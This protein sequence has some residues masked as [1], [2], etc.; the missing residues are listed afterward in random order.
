MP[1]RSAA[2]CVRAMSSW[3]WRAPRP[4]PCSSSV[5]A[6]VLFLDREH[7]L[8]GE[9]SSAAP[10]LLGHTCGAGTAFVQA[11]SELVDVK[12][13]RDAVAYLEALWGAD[14][15]RHGGRHAESAGARALRFAPPRHPLR[16]P[17]GRR[18]RAPHHR[19]DRAHF[20]AAPGA[21]HHR[22]TGT[23]RGNLRQTPG[24]R[25]RFASRAQAGL[26]AGNVDHRRGNRHGRTA[27]ARRGPAASR[28]CHGR[29]DRRSATPE[30][31]VARTFDPVESG[32]LR[33]DPGRVRRRQRRRGARRARPAR[34]TGDS[35]PSRPSCRSHGA[36]QHR[37]HRR[38]FALRRC[39]RPDRRVTL[40]ARTPTSTWPPPSLRPRPPRP[41]RVPR[42]GRIRPR[43]S[44]RRMR[45]CPRCSR[46]SCTSRPRA[47]RG[48]SP[49]RATRPASC[50]PSSNYPRA[51]RRPSA[52]SWC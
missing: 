37:R 25:D 15:D 29:R 40:P 3:W 33:I 47:S 26:A 36:G 52:R 42:P 38:G 21:A 46:K 22:S 17:G 19:F 32:Q 39:R 7:K 20:R 43:S 48:S 45:G 31:A 6:G 12:V 9:A 16:A 1:S 4:T 30:A 44:I 51:S 2:A 28:A 18:A 41:H 14:P 27:D 49:R 8:M 5:Q 24:G 34:Y 11:I 50:A 35:I 23:Q 13:R 10:E